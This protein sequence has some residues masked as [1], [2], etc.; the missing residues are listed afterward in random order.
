VALPLGSWA[1]PCPACGSG[2]CRWRSMVAARSLRP[3]LVATADGE[4]IARH[5]NA[6]AVLSPTG[7]LYR[8]NTSTDVYSRPELQA[9]QCHGAG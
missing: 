8:G 3:F 1:F 7:E 6:L 9:G 2:S 4:L 5:E